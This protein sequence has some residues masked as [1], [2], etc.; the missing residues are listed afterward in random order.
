MQRLSPFLILIACLFLA[1]CTQQPALPSTSTPG[2]TPVATKT[3]L[4]TPS[5]PPLIKSRLSTNY[6]ESGGADTFDSYQQT[7]LYQVDTE[8][9][10]EGVL[11]AR[12]RAGD[13]VQEQS[14][15]VEPDVS[16]YIFEATRPG[17][18]WS[19]GRAGVTLRLND[20]IVG[21]TKFI[22]RKSDPP[23]EF[24]PTPAGKNLPGFHRQDKHSPATSEP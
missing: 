7:L 18:A 14:L 3:T 21:Q 24:N 20:E 15:T 8:N 4:E 5:T 10:S 9:L 19:P 22:I 17:T 12:W 11:T 1:G 2:P 13:Q 6:G 23:P 16:R